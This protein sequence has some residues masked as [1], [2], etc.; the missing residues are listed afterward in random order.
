MIEIS[1][2]F[3]VYKDAFL[4]SKVFSG[5][6]IENDDAYKVSRFLTIRLSYILIVVRH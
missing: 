6:N 2:M 3:K 1:S 5:V 4:L